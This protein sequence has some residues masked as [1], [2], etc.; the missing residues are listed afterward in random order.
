MSDDSSRALR[1]ISEFFERFAGPRLS[2]ASDFDT[3]PMEFRRGDPLDGRRDAADAVPWAMKVA[4]ALS[5][6]A[7][8]IAVAAAGIVWGAMHLSIIIMPVAIA[9]LLAVLLEPLVGWFTRRLNFPRTLSAVLGLLV[10]LAVVVASLSQAG[11]EIFRQ[12]PRLFTKANDGIS[13]LMRWLGEGPLKLDTTMINQ[14]IEKVQGELANWAQANSSFLASSALS[15]T[16]SL[17]SV[18]SSVLIMLFCL[19]FFLKEG[20][21]IWLWVVR[22]FPAP[23]RQPLHESAIRGWVTLGSYVRTQIQVAAIDAIGIGLGAFFLGL[24]MVLPIVVV[25]FFA[26]FVPI[27]GALVSGAIAVLVALVD[28]G[29]TAGVIMLVVIF[30]VQQVESNLLQPLLMSH[31]VSLHPVAV[32]LVVAAS[33]SVAGI[34]GAIFGVPIAAFLNATFL[35]LHGYDSMP[36]LANDPKRPGGPPGMLEDMVAASY[37]SKTKVDPREG[38]SAVDSKDEDENGQDCSDEAPNVEPELGA[39]DEAREE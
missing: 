23:A 30:V 32:L 11:S 16:S 33:G 37:A 34:P 5:W 15:V 38:A 36:A 29:L 27:V 14:G 18:L 35:Y 13:E 24:P 9:L 3:E 7:I 2:R 8:V 12:L 17:F 31:A 20:R 10:M 25:V 6:R 21:T 39:K 22:L 26:S 28:Q 4:A 1:S 19:F